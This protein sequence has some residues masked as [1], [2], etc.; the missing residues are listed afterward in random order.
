MLLSV[1]LVITLASVTTSSNAKKHVILQPS[2][3]CQIAEENQQKVL[4]LQALL[5]EE[6]KVFITHALLATFQLA[7]QV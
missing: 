3:G 4:K 1:V 7:K 2:D 6:Q 5:Q